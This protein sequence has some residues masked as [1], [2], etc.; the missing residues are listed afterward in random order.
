[1][2]FDLYIS[3]FE[4]GEPRGVPITA[5]RAAF[6]GFLSEGDGDEW[7][8]DYGGICFS[9]VYVTS[10]DGGQML[11]SLSVNRPVKDPRLWVSLLEVLRLGNGV[12]YY[13]G[14]SAGLVGSEATIEHLP[15]GMADALGGVRCVQQPEEIVEQI[16]GS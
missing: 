3:F 4:H 16:E 11:S 2:S 7:R 8:V 10:D 15:E 6:G 14:G 1:M 5:V 12:L 9:H 13:P